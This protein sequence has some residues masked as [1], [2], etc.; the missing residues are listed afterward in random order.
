MFIFLC[1]DVV[2]QEV[3]KCGGMAT[4]TGSV[5]DNYVKHRVCRNSV[6]RIIYG[7][8]KNGPELSLPKGLNL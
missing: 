6:P 7:W 4:K 3:W 2:D 1:S 5:Q 8:A